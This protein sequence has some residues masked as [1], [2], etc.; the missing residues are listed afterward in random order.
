L[1][2]PARTVDPEMVVSHGRSVAVALLWT[3]AAI[4]AGGW[5]LDR[6][7]RD[8][9]AGELQWAHALVTGMLLWGLA[10]L[11]LGLIGA[12]HAP[13]LFGLLLLMGG[14]WWLKPRVRPAVPRVSTTAAFVGAFILLPGLIGA[15]AP[16]TGTDELYTHLAIPHQLLLDGGLSGGLLHPQG[17]RP[18]S[19]HLPYAAVMAT[20]GAGAP[21]VFHWVLSAAVLLATF[22]MGRTHLESPVA[23]ACAA[24]LVGASW[25][26]LS[27]TAR[28][29]NDIPTALAVLVALDA[30]L[31]GRGRLLAVA[32]GTALSFKY[33]AAGPIAGVFLVAALPW[34]RRARM[35]LVAIAFVAPWW[36]RNALEGLHPLFPFTGWPDVGVPMVFQHLDKYGAGRGIADMLLLPWNALMT[37]ETNSFRF[38]G[39]L[40]PAFIALAPF[41]LWAARK[42]GIARRLTLVSAITV[43]AWAVGPHWL[44]YLIP[45]LPVLA[46]ASAA[47]I[48]RPDPGWAV[49]VGAMIAGLFGVPANW[50]PLAVDTADRIAVV[51][52][53]E[54]RHVYLDRHIEGYSAIRW[55]NDHLPE[56]A[57]VAMLFSWTGA[58]VNRLQV[59]GSVEDHTPTRHWLLTHGDDSLRALASAGVTHAIVRRVRFIED[60]YPMLPPASFQTAFREPVQILRESLLMQAQ[61]LFQDDQLAVY[62]MPTA[63]Q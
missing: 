4:G 38:L 48:P 54:S 26:F 51:A 33:T 29:G 15:L 52:G 46:L 44:R 32:A 24:L 30:A 47:G 36:I 63:T 11:G 53:Q 10:G 55:A 7:A 49:A 35:G 8:E 16:A 37:A 45:G 25:T 17:S 57:R 19:L 1:L 20:G 9:T 5:V 31:R 6:C 40:T 28:I 60:A 39:R 59:L 42:A 43:V 21:A 2:D 23:G 18:L 56:D 14:C 13:V 12:L 58:H 61:L 62:Q 50:M 34:P 3:L 41:T 22:Q 27:E